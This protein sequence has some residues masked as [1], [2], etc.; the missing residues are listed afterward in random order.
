MSRLNVDEAPL[1]SKEGKGDRLF[2]LD[3]NEKIATV[4]AIVDDSTAPQ[5]TEGAD[6]EETDTEDGDIETD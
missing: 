1:E 4:T 6:S 2:K 5:E 3:S